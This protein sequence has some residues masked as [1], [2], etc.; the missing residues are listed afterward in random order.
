MTLMNIDTMHDIIQINCEFAET[1][2]NYLIK[3]SLKRMFF[4]WFV[5]LKVAKQ[6]FADDDKVWMKNVQWK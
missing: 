5:C 4:P 1:N 2:E 6:S 3:F